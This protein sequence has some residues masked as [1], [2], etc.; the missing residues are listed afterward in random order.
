MSS[1]TT[2]LDR[3][4]VEIIFM[5]FDYLSSNEIIYTFFFFN[6]RMNNFLLQNEDYLNYSE[7]PTTDFDIWEHI[8][9][10]IGCRIHTLNVTTI[11]L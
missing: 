5:I 11:D 7:L 4:P 3:F 1:T 8:L 9:S 2:W 10:I 6:Q